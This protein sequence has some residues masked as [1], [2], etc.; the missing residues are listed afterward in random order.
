MCGSNAKSDLIKSILA[1]T[2][3]SD[4]KEVVAKFVVETSQESNEKQIFVFNSNGNSNKKNFRSKNNFRKYATRQLK[5]I[6][7]LLA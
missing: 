2:Q 5:V 4:P 7:E 6:F 1:A 3:F